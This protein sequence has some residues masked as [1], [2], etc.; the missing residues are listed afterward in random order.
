MGG[1]LKQAV[2]QGSPF[3]AA[4]TVPIVMATASLALILLFWRDG[5]TALATWRSSSAYGYCPLVPLIS[6]ALL[7]AGRAGWRLDGVRLS[8][9]GCLLFLFWLALWSLGQAALINEIRQFAVVGMMQALLLCL[10]G[11]RLIK[12]CLFPLLYLFLMVPTATV[13]L[14]PLQSLTATLA[15]LVLRL[16]AI[17]VFISGHL[18]EVPHGLYEVAPGCSGLNFLLSALALSL[19][20]GHVLYQ[21]ATKRIACVLIALLMAILTNAVRVFGIIWLAEAT[22]R[23]IDIVNDHLVYGWVVYCTAMGAAM[24]VGLRFRDPGPPVPDLSGTDC[25]I[26]W[27]RRLAA[28]LTLLFLAGVVQAAIPMTR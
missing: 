6:L 11:W 16:A 23:R 18:I 22:D 8:G 9:A 19:V 12:Q 25:A 21:G 10:F 26:A 7:N 2:S 4:R 14:A 24:L 20:Y 5:A 17:P 13:L 28:L 1:S 3:T 15:G 27:P